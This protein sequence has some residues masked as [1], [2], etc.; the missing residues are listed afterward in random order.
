MVL[1]EVGIGIDN[2]CKGRSILEH[3]EHQIDHDACTLEARFAVAD[4]WIDG[5]ILS[6]LH[7]KYTTT[8]LA[9]G[10]MLKS[11]GLTLWEADA[12][13][14]HINVIG[15]KETHPIPGAVF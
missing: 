6:Y 9:E 8:F 14:L 12:S 13:V 15:S 2:V 7:T 11:Q 10:I 3:I 1:S 5:N 4:V